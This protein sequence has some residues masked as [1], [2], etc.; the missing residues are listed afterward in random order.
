MVGNEPSARLTHAIADS[1]NAARTGLA[2]EKLIV[3]GRGDRFRE[4]TLSDHFPFWERDIPAVMVTDTAF[5]RNPHYHLPSDTL[6]T[7]DLEF[8]HKV[9]GGICAFLQG[10]LQ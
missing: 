4:V 10:Y 1:M 6:E 5:L 8:I 9:T 3:P 2:A 7:L